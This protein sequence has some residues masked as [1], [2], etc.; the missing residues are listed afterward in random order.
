MKKIR[1][2]KVRNASEM[3]KVIKAH[4]Y[5]MLKINGFHVGYVIECIYKI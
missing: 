3:G 1:L 4:P 2:Q 5:W